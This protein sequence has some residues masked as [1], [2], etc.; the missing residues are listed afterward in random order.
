V[1]PASAPRVTLHPRGIAPYVVN[2]EPCSA[3]LPARL[4]RRAGLTADG[5]LDARHRER[6]LPGRRRGVRIGGRRRGDRD[7]VAAASRR[8]R[9]GL[10]STISISES[11]VDITLAELALEAFFRPTTSPPPALGAR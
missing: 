6:G 11:A 4:R 5:E 2:F 7:A 3:H 9:A 8:P 10:P 1:P